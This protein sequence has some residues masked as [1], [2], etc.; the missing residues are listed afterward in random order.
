MKSGCGWVT[1]RPPCGGQ[2]LP[3]QLLV[4]AMAIRLPASGSSSQPSSPFLALGC[5]R[6]PLVYWARPL[7]RRCPGRSRDSDGAPIAARNWE[8]TNMTAT[9]RQ[10]PP[11]RQACNSSVSRFAFFQGIGFGAAGPG[12]LAPIRL[13]G[14][15]TTR[16]P[17]L[18]LP[19]ASGF[20]FCCLT[21]GCKPI[22]NIGWRHASGFA[23]V[24]T[25]ELL[26]RY[27][28]VLF[29]SARA[30]TAVPPARCGKCQELRNC[31]VSS[32][33][34]STNRHFLNC[35]TLMRFTFAQPAGHPVPGKT[36]RFLNHRDV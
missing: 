7:S 21:A 31:S 10:M 34:R 29:P 27:L 24:R 6:F 11:I 18:L 26:I 12:G 4:M 14:S 36:L 2:L 3:S 1:C 33:G 17:G 28:V 13:G 15:H 23:V 20:L 16:R 35:P 19:G 9:N 8:Q 5:L 32:P 30:V 22:P 25:A